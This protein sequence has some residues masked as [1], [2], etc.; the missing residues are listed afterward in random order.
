[1]LVAKTVKKISPLTFGALG[2]ALVAFGIRVWFALVHWPELGGD[3][4]IMNLMAL[5]IMEKGEHPVFFYGQSY[6]GA[7][8]AYPGAILFRL[9][10][11]SFTVMRVE[12]AGFFMLFLFTLYHL[13]AR[14]YT[15]AF[16]LCVIVILSVGSIAMANFQ[17][18]AA[19]GYPELPLIGALAHI[20]SCPLHWRRGDEESYCICCGG[21]WLG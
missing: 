7:I 13:A 12:M 5:H 16:A 1:M 20:A 11:P 10:G 3:E 6:M 19:G 15:K 4:A 21:W 14:L 18:L 8:E 9:F 17:L 2:I